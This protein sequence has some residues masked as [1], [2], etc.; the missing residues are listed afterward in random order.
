MLVQIFISCQNNQV[1]EEN[2]NFWNLNSGIIDFTTYNMA[3]MPSECCCTS[4]VPNKLSKW[5]TFFCSI[6]FEVCMYS[7]S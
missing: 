2:S 7:L 5:F 6:S 4:K 1:C 3:K